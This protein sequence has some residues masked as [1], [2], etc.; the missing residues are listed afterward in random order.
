MA[1]EKLHW[2]N[3]VTKVNATNMN[4]IENGIEANDVAIGDLSN[5]TTTEKASVVGAINELDSPTNNILWE[6]GI[7][8]HATQTVSLSQNVTDQKHGIVLVWTNYENAQ[9]QN[10][11]VNCFFIPKKYVELYPGLGHGMLM[12]H[13]W[14]ANLGKKYVY[15]SN[16]KI[17]GVASNGKE[18]S[19]G[20]ITWYNNQYVLRYVIGV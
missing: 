1:Y 19:Q 18:V 14:N 15:I 13:G 20:G 12:T 3:D 8:V 16:D 4:R 10:N 9:A 17:T 11:G 6:G 2:V 5:L 7:Y